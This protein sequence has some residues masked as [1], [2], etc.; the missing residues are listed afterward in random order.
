MIP[1]IRRLSRFL[2]VLRVF[3]LESGV[4]VRFGVC[5]SDANGCSVVVVAVA[6]PPSK[7]VEYLP[8][9]GLGVDN[10]C[11]LEVT[12]S[13]ALYLCDAS[14][15]ACILDCSPVLDEDAPVPRM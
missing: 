12:Y 11:P 13:F 10:L 8:R 15:A 1:D 2:N 3:C 14:L 9:R 5:N 6:P 4:I 7:E